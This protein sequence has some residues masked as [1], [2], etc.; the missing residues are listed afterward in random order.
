MHSC[1]PSWCWRGITLSQM[2]VKYLSLSISALLLGKISQ[3]EICSLHLAD[4]AFR[5][6]LL[7]F[8]KNRCKWWQSI[9]KTDLRPKSN[10]Q[11][12][13]SN[14]RASFYLGEVGG[15]ISGA[16]TSTLRG[17]LFFWWLVM[18]SLHMG[19]GFKIGIVVLEQGIWWFLAC[20]L[21]TVK[22]PFA[23]PVI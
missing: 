21:G 12:V 1:V 15:Y 14:M 5:Q 17:C 3:Q 8:S 6:K 13:W 2:E 22:P 19:V 16:V 4:F 20:N 10:L 18:F 23:N 9:L 7:N 11:M